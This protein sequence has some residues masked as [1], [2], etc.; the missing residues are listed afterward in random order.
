MKREKKVTSEL[1]GGFSDY[2]VYEGWNL[3]GWPVKTIVRGEL[4]ADDFQVI[5][6]PGYGKFVERKKH[7]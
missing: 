3:K 6:K 4:V 2:I 7:F 1:F 5:S